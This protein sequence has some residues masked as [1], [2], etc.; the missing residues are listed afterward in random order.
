MNSYSFP[1]AD[2]LLS[3]LSKVDYQKLWNRILSAILFTGALIY[4]LITRLSVWYQNGGQE[5][6]QQ[7]YIQS[8]ELFSLFILWLC[9]DAIPALRSLYK[10]SKETISEARSRMTNVTL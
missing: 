3:Y 7:R 2:D 10:V 4:V 9:D 6:I 1:P 5:S 8:R